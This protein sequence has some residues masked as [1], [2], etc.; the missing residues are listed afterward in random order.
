MWW[1]LSSICTWETGDSWRSLDSAAVR[2][3][4]HWHLVGWGRH[5]H[6]WLRQAFSLWD[7][8]SQFVFPTLFWLLWNIK[9]IIGWQTPKWSDIKACYM[10]I[11]VSN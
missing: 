2:P 1:S 10:K 9:E 11:H 3:G 8:N 4:G 5:S 7:K 6:W